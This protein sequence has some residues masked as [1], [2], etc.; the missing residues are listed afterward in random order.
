MTSSALLVIDA[1]I[2][3]FA[4]TNPV[5]SADQL[6]GR[7]VTLVERARAA[8]VPII[9]VR[10]CGTEGEPDERGTPG[11]E[12][13]PALQPKNG[14]LLLDK[15]TND[16]FESTALDKNLKDRGIRHLII[17]GLQSEYC[18]AKTTSGALARDY[19]V[20]LVTDGH[21]TYADASQSAFD[22]SVAVNAQFA[23][24]VK[25]ATTAEVRFA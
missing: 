8:S 3:M 10:N 15:T 13:H 7:L 6:L 18:I 20:T 12:L 22:K 2:N 14:E 17:I 21:S 24:R 19:E 4:A 25:L 9:L 11:W 23:G 16:T 5:W 1:Q